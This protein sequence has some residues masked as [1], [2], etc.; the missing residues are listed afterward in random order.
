MLIK[1]ID[2]TEKTATVILS[3]DDLRCLNNSLYHVSEQECKK[4]ADFNTVYSNILLLFTLA[5]YGKLPAFEFDHISKLRHKGSAN[6]ST[7][8]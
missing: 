2:A 3:Y 1:A 5:K 6:E 7:N 4:D 8:E